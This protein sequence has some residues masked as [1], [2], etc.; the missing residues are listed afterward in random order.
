MGMTERN[1]LKDT[2]E[3]VTHLETLEL[4]RDGLIEAVRYADAERA[5]CT[6][7][8]RKGW[9]L[10]VMSDKAARALRERY[11]GPRWISDETDGQAG[12]YNPHLKVRIIPCNFDENAGNPLKD[13]R[14]RTP[15]GSATRAKTLCNAT[16]WLPGLEP[17]PADSEDEIVTYIL[18]IFSENDVPLRAE[19]SRP[20]TFVGGEFV[21]FAPRIL[22]LDGTECPID[23]EG[24]ASDRDGPTELIDIEIKRK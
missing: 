23:R 15:K 19:L 8:D 21:K 5:L 3:V 22:L 18:G 2:D 11:C 20:V 14:N 10:I 17:P 4:D 7:Y 13:P 16:A 9:G 24:R 1:L 12:I 6:S